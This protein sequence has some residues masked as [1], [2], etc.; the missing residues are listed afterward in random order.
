MDGVQVN[1]EEALRH[2][3]TMEGLA[4]SLGVQSDDVRAAN[5]SFPK[6]EP[7]AP[8]VDAS[9]TSSGARKV[10]IRSDARICAIPR[11]FA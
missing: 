3:G 1:E 2:S 10:T 11:G 9:C 4:K 7:Y 5:G 6:A 8:I